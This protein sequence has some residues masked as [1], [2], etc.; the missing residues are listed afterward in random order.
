MADPK[1]PAKLGRY[2]VIR[3]LGKGAMGVVY[4]GKD[5][6]IGRRVAIKTARREVV[7]A[8]GM[9]D[10]MMERFLREAKAAGA[11]NHPNIITIYDAAEE[12][13]MAYIAMEYLEGGDLADIVD[14]RKRLGMEEIV[15]IGANICEA[16]HVAHEHGVVHRDIKPANILMPKDKPLKVADF[17]IAHVSDSNLT[18]DGALI[19][20]PHYMSPEQFMGQK[21]DGRSDLFS[22]GNILYE[23]TTGEKPFGGEALSTVMHRVIKIDPV[24]PTELNFAIPDALAGVIMKA[25]S[26]R[27]ASRFKTG[28]EMAAAL[29]ESLK[30]NPNPA[31]LD[32]GA[33][34]A[35][36]STMAAPAPAAPVQATMISQPA[37]EDFKST[38]VGSRP[39]SQETTIAGPGPDATVPGGS[40]GPEATVAGPPPASAVDVGATVPGLAPA[41]I[42]SAP[43]PSAGPN[44]GLLIGGGIAVAL[45]VIIGG[46]MMSGG[47]KTETPTKTPPPDSKN[48]ASTA[49]SDR[50]Y[51]AAIFEIYRAN[52]ED[53]YKRFMQKEATLDDLAGKLSEVSGTIAI[54]L[55]D[56]AGNVLA[57]APAWSAGDLIEIPAERKVGAM[58]YR[59]TITDPAQ[60]G[61]EGESFTDEIEPASTPEA[62]ANVPIIFGPVSTL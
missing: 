37:S 42:Q 61:S 32:P 56:S 26:K 22:V 13:G 50:Y 30:E 19:G 14:S 60:P 16:L 9:A 49:S 7:E 28:N 38:V 27:P 2:E 11:L 57:S 20:T 33:S 46:I 29:R 4:E 51:T 25:L 53:D 24:S 21:L 17:G 58:S 44:K 35:L 36:S 40:P 43:T 5:P 39:A 45:V 3:E 6:N 54:E 1:M 52:T 15:E 55:L 62:T 23:L 12:D 59:V 34:V 47:E 41:Q 18:Q 31:I 10:E 8:S 48:G